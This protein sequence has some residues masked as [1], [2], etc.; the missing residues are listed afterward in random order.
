MTVRIKDENE[1]QTLGL[2]LDPN[3]S[4]KAVP[5]GNGTAKKPVATKSL[6][7]GK[8]PFSVKGLSA[9]SFTQKQLIECARYQWGQLQAAEKKAAVHVFRLGAALALL[10]PSLK[11]QR[12][13]GKVLKDLHI[14]EAT[15]WRATELFT[16]AKTEDQVAL[17]TITEAYLAFGILGQLEIPADEDGG[18]D[19]AAEMGHKKKVVAKKAVAKKKKPQPKDVADKGSTNNDEQVGKYEEVGQ[20]NDEDE[21]D[22]FDSGELFDEVAKRN[23]WDAQRQVQAMVDYWSTDALGTLLMD[24]AD[25]ADFKDFLTQQEKL[26]PLKEPMTPLAVLVMLRNRLE[27][28]VED[29]KAID[30]KEESSEDYRKLLDAIRQ[31]VEQIRTGVAQ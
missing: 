27:Y 7:G 22:D 4:K 30:W 3:D 21:D 16:R 5:L 6:N 18:E 11:K 13:W 10:K 26:P 9:P 8:K 14:A 28:V 17:L 2:T 29:V 25:E 1:L 23:G 19:N 24:V 12:R 31:L 15:A 20:P